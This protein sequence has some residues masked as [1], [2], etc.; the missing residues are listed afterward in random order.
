[1]ES[2]HALKTGKLISLSESQIVECDTNGT[3]EGCMGG[4]MD[5]AFEYVINTGGIESEKD[6]PYDPNGNPCT[7]N[8]SKVVA[9]FF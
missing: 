7:F 2:A 8:K 4:W 3:D 9:K 5:G 6:Y 1:M